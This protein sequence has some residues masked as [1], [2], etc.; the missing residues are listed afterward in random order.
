MKGFHRRKRLEFVLSNLVCGMNSILRLLKSHFTLFNSELI[1]RLLK[2]LSGRDS[3][4]WFHIDMVGIKAFH[5][6]AAVTSF[7]AKTE[8]SE[9]YS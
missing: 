2:Y 7:P 9:F 6:F 1:L 5:P 8:C 3:A 4:S